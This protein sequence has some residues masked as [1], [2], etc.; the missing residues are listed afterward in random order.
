MSWLKNLHA[1]YENCFGKNFDGDAKLMPICHTKQNAQIE[2]TIDGD[3]NFRRAT[4]IKSDNA[5]LVP[6]TESSAGRAGSKPTNHPLCDKLQ[7]LAG[8]FNDYGGD[9]TS[10]FAKNPTQ[11]F[12]DYLASLSSWCESPHSNPKV[13]AIFKY[14]SSKT[15]VK[16][17]VESQLIPLDPATGKELKA[18]SGEKEDTPLIFKS[19]P[20]NYSPLDAFVRWNVEITGEPS[21]ALSDDRSVIESWISYYCSL[22]EET[23]GVCFITGQE[24]VLSIQHPSKI[25]HAGD[26]AKLISGNDGTG[27]TFRGRFTDKDPDQA[28]N[29]SFDVSQKAHNALRWLIERQG[30]R[31]GDL[32]YVT[33]APEFKDIPDPFVSTPGLF[34]SVE[35]DDPDD[36]SMS[37]AVHDVGQH[38]A[39][40]LNKA[41]SGYRSHLTAHD[42]IVVLGVDSAT[43]GRLSIVL[44]RDISGSDFLQR[45]EDWHSNFAWPQNYSKKL[46]FVGAPSPV[47]IAEAVFGSRLDEKL[48][49]STVQRIIPCI[50]DG[51]SLPADLVRTAVNRMTQRM[52]MDAWEW[53]KFLGITC[54]IFK[55]FSLSKQKEYSMSLETDNNSRDYLYGRL[56]AIAEH[57]EMRALFLA[58]ERRDTNAARQM[59][60]FADFPFSTWKNLE[61]AITPY[62]SQLRSKRGALLK[63]LES[64]L[65][66]VMTKFSSADFK[67]D[68]RLSGEFLLAYHCQRAELWKDPITEETTE[69]ATAN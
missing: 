20:N 61:L 9:V 48:K 11:P 5:T 43:P 52:S 10:G 24:A 50:I 33:W 41:I 18:W 56:L 32:V 26:K 25:R 12:E 34:G 60:R 49:Q 51:S 65:D 59:Q 3:G 17:L 66:E 30:Y 19:L 28:A 68:T 35:D 13:E 29:V 23:G 42:S 54:S 62:K 7:Y 47:D 22:T 55:G 39:T 58:D 45:I 14:V 15:L 37:I 46:K 64:E 8:D 31:N 4:V 6:C 67:S 57:I 36:T 16:D 1:T 27:Y 44:Q 69:P 40:Q 53:N 2:V 21:S 63:R 38:F